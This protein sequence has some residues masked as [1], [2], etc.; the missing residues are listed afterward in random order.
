MN[1]TKMKINF[2]HTRLSLRYAM[3]TVIVSL[4]ILAASCS[5]DENLSGNNLNLPGLVN[6]QSVR[7][8][9]FSSGNTRSLPEAPV[10]VDTIKNSRRPIRRNQH[11]RGDRS[12]YPR[13]RCHQP[14]PKH[15]VPHASTG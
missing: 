9:G 10:V 2:T 14:F 12:I 5:Q 7:I 4:S 1:K 8:A 11:R 3:F 13:K 15:T 6:L